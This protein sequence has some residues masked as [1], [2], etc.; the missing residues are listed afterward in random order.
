MYAYIR[1]T[2]RW[3]C[4]HNGRTF[5]MRAPRVHAQTAKNKYA[6]AYA[7]ACSRAHSILKSSVRA[8]RERTLRSVHFLDC[9][10]RLTSSLTHKGNPSTG[11]AVVCHSCARDHGC[12]IHAIHV[13][14]CVSVSLLMRE[15]WVCVCPRIGAY[16][17]RLAD[18]PVA[19]RAPEPQADAEDDRK[20]YVT[21]TS[22]GASIA[23][24]F[25]H[26]NVATTDETVDCGSTPRPP[27]VRRA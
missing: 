24:Y 18:R 8:L 27:K 11:D 1:R 4:V 9:D 19:E 23:S 16:D 7:H 15:L 10:S 3:L 21:C 22:T 2:L 26:C 13:S 20:S 5:T 6:C 14:M 25:C 17:E 12:I